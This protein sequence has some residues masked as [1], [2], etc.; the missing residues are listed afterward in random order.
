[1]LDGR[2][3]SAVDLQ[4]LYL[5]AAQQLD[6]AQDEGTSWLLREWENVLND[7]ERDVTLTRDR[8]DWAAKKFLLNAMREEERL[9]WS[10]PWLQ[11]IDLEYHGVDPEQGL[12]YDLERRGLMR[13][14]VTEEDISDAISSPPATTRAFFRGRAIAKYGDAISAV[15]WD[16]VVFAD[17]GRTKRVALW[18]VAHDARLARL[19]AAVNECDTATD[20]LRAIAAEL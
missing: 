7:L 13:R 12:F 2:K 18:E 1:M 9:S 15:Q 14:V 10:D 3:I 20:F 4:R 6:S 19:N 17:R 11:S 16:E 5:R 8:V